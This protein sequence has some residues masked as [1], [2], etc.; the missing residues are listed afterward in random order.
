VCTR[1]GRIIQLRLGSKFGVSQNR[2]LLL[3][4]PDLVLLKPSISIQDAVPLV[5]QRFRVRPSD[6][7]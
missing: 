3:M 2:S 7:K 4:A 1:F 6:S 5:N